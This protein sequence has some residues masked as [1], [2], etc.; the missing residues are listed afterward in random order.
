[1]A[2][3]AAG[4]GKVGGNGGNGGKLSTTVA[5]LAIGGNIYNKYLI[6]N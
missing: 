4:G 6:F 3:V 5:M 1:V 2:E